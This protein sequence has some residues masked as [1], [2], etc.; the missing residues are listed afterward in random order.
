MH[1]K[2]WAVLV[3]ILVSITLSCRDKAQ[4]RENDQREDSG[5]AV[6]SRSGEERPG[7]KIVARNTQIDATNAYDDLFLDSADMEAF[8]SHQ[9][10]NDTLAN[11]FRNFYNV[12]NYQLAWFASDGLTEQALAFSSLY[13]YSKDSSTHRK[14]LDEKLDSFLTADSLNFRAVDEGVLRTELL[15]T[16]RFINYLAVRYP[17]ETERTDALLRLVPN[18]KR[19]ALEMAKAVLDSKPGKDKA[20]NPWYEALAGPLEKYLALALNAGNMPPLPSA[21]KR[22]QKGDRAPLISAVKRRL[23]LTG[24]FGNTGDSTNLFDAELERSIRAFQAAHGLDTDGKIRKAL[25]TEL[26]IPPLTRI[27]KILL[28]LERMSW[29]PPDPAGKLILVNIPEYRLHVQEDGKRVFDMKVVVGKEGHGTVLFSGSLDRITFNPYWNIPPSIVQKEIVPS[30]EKNRHYLE[31][32]DMEI[33]G[34]E[35]G[36]PVIRQVPGPKNELGKVKFLFPNSYNIYLHDTP[37]KE[38]FDQ[39]Q[40]A[41]SHGCIR[42][43]EPRRL[44]DYLLQGMKEWDTGKSDSVLASNKER[45][46]KLQDPVAVLICYF[47]AWAEDGTT[48][49]FRKDIYGHDAKLAAKMFHIQRDSSLPGY[50]R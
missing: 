17:D 23:Q 32:N 13:N 34:E 46:I 50:Y 36:L 30:M 35:K 19:D 43:A 47:T 12:R 28:N 5:K 42:I 26:N 7:G 14:W 29:M 38:L 1:Q 49:Q 44:A 18:R 31:E 37:H 41:Y 6:T 4:Q 8:I 11:S 20:I 40:R 48:L 10:L 21:K 2:R 16:W 45:T 22:Y 9:Q 15:M 25:I 24:E 27:R 3:S 33:T 39:N